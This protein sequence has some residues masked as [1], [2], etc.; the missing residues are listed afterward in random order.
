MHLLIDDVLVG[1]VYDG[2]FGQSGAPHA[3]HRVLDIGTKRTLS[4]QPSEIK[5]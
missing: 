4:Q 3:V 2:V 1:H 5:V